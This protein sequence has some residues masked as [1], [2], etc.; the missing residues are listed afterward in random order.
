MKQFYI[1]P[2]ICYG[3]FSIISDVK[4]NSV[5]SEMYRL[6]NHPGDEGGLVWNWWSRTFDKK[7][8]LEEGVDLIIDK[9]KDQKWKGL[10]D[11]L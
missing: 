1:L 5:T 11:T 3:F 10:K 7:W 8:P 6:S 4:Q 9:W 2:N